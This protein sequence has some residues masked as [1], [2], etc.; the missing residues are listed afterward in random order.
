MAASPLP[1][2]SSFSVAFAVASLVAACGTYEPQVPPGPVTLESLCAEGA[3]RHQRCTGGKG[4]VPSITR[5]CVEGLPCVERVLRPEAAPIFARCRARAECGTDCLHD[6]GALLG[7]TPGNSRLRAD[8][9][10]IASTIERKRCT[11]IVDDPSYNLF[12]DEIWTRISACRKL[13]DGPA[14]SRCFSEATMAP[15]KELA[16]CSPLLADLPLRQ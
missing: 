1:R 3:P 16:S 9:G 4:D 2:R 10:E 6:A 8:C 7:V 11:Q 14:I 5:A 15:V 12:R 13:P